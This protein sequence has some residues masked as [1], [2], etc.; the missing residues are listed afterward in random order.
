MQSGRVGF[1]YSTIIDTVYLTSIAA[2]VK[3]CLTA[4]CVVVQYGGTTSLLKPS[5]WV[6]GYAADDWVTVEVLIIRRVPSDKKLRGY[7]Q[8][9]GPDFFG[10]CCC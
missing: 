8:I 10:I 5:Q 3:G 6:S 7:P 1:A 2:P 9:L 4:N